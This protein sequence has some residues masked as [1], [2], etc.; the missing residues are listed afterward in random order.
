MLPQ[1]DPTWYASQ[2]F[3]MLVTFCAMFLAVWRLVMPA[4]R[5]TV[6]VRRSKIEENIKQTEILKTEAARLL[7][8][9]DA[10]RAS[11]RENTARLM[12]QAQEQ[13]QAQTAQS[14]AEFTARLNE[15]IAQKEQALKQARE[16]ALREVASISGELT[17][18]IVRKI[19]G[20]TV[21]ADE[22]RQE[23][24]SVMEKSA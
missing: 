5:A 12:A 3:W 6:D 9:L 7:K 13:A 22:I 23:T 19:G 11:V 18:A 4:M 1:L 24:A 14:E 20:I 16:S 2:S 10:A 21:P 15:H 8:E 17:D